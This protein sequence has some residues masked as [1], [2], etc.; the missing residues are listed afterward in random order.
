MMLY[1]AWQKDY[2]NPPVTTPA[3]DIPAAPAGDPAGT[4]LLDTPDTPDLPATAT[5]EIQTQGSEPAA[6]VKRQPARSVTVMTDVYHMRIG[7]RGAGIIKAELVKYPVSLDKPDQPL[8]LMDETNQLFFITQSGLLSNDDSPNHGTVFHA[9]S[10]SYSLSPDQ[11]VLEVPFTWSSGDGLEVKKIFEFQRGSYQIGVRYEIAN[12]RA[13]AWNGWLYSQ[14]KRNN[15]GSKRKLGSYSYTGSV[16]SSPDDRYQKIS[17][18]DISEQEIEEDISN[19]WVAMIQHYFVSAL[20]PVDK[21][22]PYHFYTRALSDGNFAIGLRSP[23]ITISQG[24]DQTV[25]ETI[26]IGPKIQKDLEEIADGLELTVDYGLLWFLAKPLFW[27][28]SS[29]HNITH[30]WGWAIIL[31]TIFL[32]V[33]FYPLSA[34]GYRSMANMRKVQPRLVS[35]RERYKDD[36]ARLNQ[37]MMQLYK[38]EKI[39]PFGGCFPILVQIPVFMAL[40]WVLLETVEMRQAGFLFWIRDLSSP[41]PFYVLPLLMG[42]TMFISQKLNPAPLDPIQAK[43]MQVL[44]VVFTIFFA[45]LQ[46]GLVLYSVVN[47]TLSIAQQWLITRNIERAGLNTGKS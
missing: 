28:L 41:D 40:Y 32:K 29:L 20:I 27:C 25:R 3:T 21:T 39:N 37:A 26:Y 17:F 33:V 13:Q 4:G 38:E 19:G 11:T 18:D 45:F 16:L 42:I 8:V 30:N 31:L 15:P 2:G 5:G 35:I 22:A 43:V 1:Q 44:P 34:A 6:T 10:D 24:G 23:P 14:L 36:K 47:S 7:L 46:S 12:N 9:A